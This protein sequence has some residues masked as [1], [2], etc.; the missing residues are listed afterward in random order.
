MVEQT[1]TRRCSGRQQDPPVNP[2]ATHQDL[3]SKSRFLNI[4]LFPWRDLSF[5]Y[6]QQYF[7]FSE[8]A[9]NFLN[10]LLLTI[11]SRS[12]MDRQILEVPTVATR[13]LQ[14]LFQSNYQDKMSRRWQLIRTLGCF[15]LILNRKNSCGKNIA[16]KIKHR[17]IGENCYNLRQK[18]LDLFSFAQKHG[19]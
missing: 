9:D 6:L 4:R 14:R 1:T 3:F 7:Y 2:A 15:S 17:L 16:D 10:L 11:F 8:V 5:L 12:G 19:T 18:C 13:P